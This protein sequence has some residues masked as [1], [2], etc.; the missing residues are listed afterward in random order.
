MEYRASV[1]LTPASPPMLAR[2][3]RPEAQSRLGGS[4][5]SSLVWSRCRHVDLKLMAD[6][7][8]QSE[9]EEDVFTETEGGA[10]V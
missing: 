4:Y 2:G 5:Q 6:S 7:S 3:G 8:V 1:P 10:A 9:S